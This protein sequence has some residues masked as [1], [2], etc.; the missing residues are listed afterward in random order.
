MEKVK[1]SHN[2]PMEAQ[3]ERMYNSYSLKTSAL[4]WV[5]GHRHAPAAL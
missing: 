3:G 4:D 2:T 5:S 1:Q